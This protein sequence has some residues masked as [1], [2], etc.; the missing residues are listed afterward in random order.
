MIIDEDIYE[1]TGPDVWTGRL[2]SNNDMHYWHQVVS[3]SDIRS[4]PEKISKHSFGIIGYACDEGVRRNQGRVGASAGPDQVRE[5]L[6]KLS[7]H[8]DAEVHDFGN[9]RCDDG[10]LGA[11]QL[12]LATVIATVL[13]YNHFPIVIGGGHD[14]AWG[15]FQ[16][17]KRHLGKETSIGVINFDAHL[18]LR[19]VVDQGNSGTPFNQ[20]LHEFP[21]SKY[22]AVGIQKRSNNKELY[23]IAKDQ[24]VSMVHLPE[25]SLNEIDVVKDRLEAFINSVDSIYVTIDLDGF[26]AAYAPGVSAPSPLGLRPEFVME[27]MTHIFNSRKVVSCDLAELNPTYDRDHLTARLAAILVDHMVGGICRNN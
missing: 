8:H 22:F 9:V 3:R 26:S 11:S 24:N 6:S 12:G 19:P 13:E 17:L 23:K 25:C 16:G 5:R 27:L 21:N 4:M 1:L 10:H 2:P 20:I 14:I 7:W 18:D 15:H